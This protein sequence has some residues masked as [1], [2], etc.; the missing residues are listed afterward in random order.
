MRCQKL[1]VLKFRCV[2]GFIQPP[3]QLE[4]LRED[5]DGDIELRTTVKGGDNCFSAGQSSARLSIESYRA[6]DKKPIK[7]SDWLAARDQID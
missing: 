2:P 3:D 4:K 1:N 7:R 5:W 6:R